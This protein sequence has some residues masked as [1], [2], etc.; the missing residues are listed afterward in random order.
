[1]SDLIDQNAHS[2]ADDTPVSAKHMRVLVLST[3]PKITS[4]EN[5]PKWLRKTVQIARVGSTTR[6]RP[7]RNPAVRSEGRAP[8]RTYAI[9]A[10]EEASSPNLTTHDVTLNCGKKY[11]EL[12]CE[13]WDTLYVESDEQD[14]SSVVISHMSAQR[15]V[16]K[17]YEVYLSFAMNAKETELKLASNT[18]QISIAPYR[19][20]PIELKE[21]KAQLQELTDKGF[22][23]QV[24]LH[25]VLQYY[26]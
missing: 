2:V 11:I 13:N 20:A 6:E 12:R 5:T 9:R 16:R 14:R 26:L 4:F 17:G 7:Q 10:R 1:M 19:M 22:A 25:G 23:D 3:V 15:Y 24:V 18:V 21:L 8:T